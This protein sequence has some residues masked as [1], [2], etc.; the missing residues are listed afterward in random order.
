MPSSLEQYL[1]RI[2][3][4]WD[5]DAPGQLHRLIEGSM[6]FVDISGFT[7]MSERLARHGRVGAEEVTDV[8]DSTFGQLL[9]EAYAHGANL[10]KFG[11]DA[12]LLLFTE[13]GHAVRAA[14]AGQAM[15]RK[16]R[17]IGSFATSAGA[18]VLRMTMGIHSGMFD[19]FMVGRSHRELIVTGPAVTRTVE[20]ESAAETGQIL[21]SP[22]TAR[23]IP[24]RSLGSRSGPGVLLRD[25]LTEVERL[26]IRPA[27]A[28]D[29]DLAPFVPVALRER[30]LAGDLG[31][32]HRPATIAFIGYQGVDRVIGDKGA[33]TAALA[34]DELMTMVQVAADTHKVTL[35][36]TD[37]A[38]DGG[39]IILTAG[40]PIASG[41]DEE[42]LLLAVNQ[43][44]S[45]RP[46]LPIR[47]GVTWGSIFAGEVGPSYRRTYTVMGDA[48]NLAARLMAKSAPGEVLTTPEVLEGSRTLFQA[49]EVAPFF[50]KGKKAPVVAR[51]L[52][53]PTGTRIST[54]G[55]P[56]VGREAEL[57]LMLDKWS[58]AQLRPG[59][60]VELVAEPGMGKSRLLEEFLNRAAGERIVR[61]ECRL[62]QSAT[63]YF[64]FRALLRQALGID[65]NDAEKSGTQLR[66]LVETRT[67]ELVAWLP[68]IAAALNLEWLDTP[69][70]AML[71]NQFRPARTIE[72]VRYLLEGVSST[73]TI[74]VVEDTHWMDEASRELLDGLVGALEKNPW[75]LILTSRPAQAGSPAVDRPSAIQITLQPL[76]Q[77]DA[78]SLIV[79]ATEAHPLPSQQVKALA[80]R[81]AGSPLFLIELLQ[82]LKRGS[83]VDSLPQSVEGLIGARIDKLPAADRNLLRRLSVLGAGFQVEHTAAVL[84]DTKLSERNRAIHRMSG[85][86]SI[87]QSGWVQFRHALIRDVAYGGLPFNTRRRLHAQVG[88]SICAAAG[89]QVDSQAELLSFHFFQAQDYAGAWRFSLTAGRRAAHVYANVEAA[90]FLERALHAGPRRSAAGPEEL[91]DAY[92]LLGDVQERL[93]DYTRAVRAYSTARKLVPH[94]PAQAARLLDKQSLMAEHSGNF[95]QALR[96]LSQG[97][98]LLTM[99]DGPEQVG[100]RAKLMGGYGAVRLEQGQ[101]REAI[102]WARRAIAEAETTEEKAALAQAYLTLDIAL[103]EVGEPADAPYAHLALSLFEQLEDLAG[104]ANTLNNMGAEAYWRGRWDEAR[105]LFERSQRARERMGDEVNAAD[106]LNNVAE[107]L[108]DQ[109]RLAEAEA[110]FRTTLRVRQAFNHRIGLA[111][112]WS[113]LGRVA[114]RSGRNAEA[115]AFLEQARSEFAELKMAHE[116][117]ETDARIAECLL[118]GGQWE[119]AQEVIERALIEANQ[120]G[121]TTAQAPM[122]YR[123]RSWASIQAG[124]PAEAAA[125][126]AISLQHGRARGADYEVALTLNV[127]SALVRVLGENPDPLE[128]AEQHEIL[129]RL[130]VVFLPTVYVHEADLTAP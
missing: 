10:L 16:L 43:L 85:L 58:Q 120:V 66:E 6:V 42:Q 88:Q 19:F 114:Y 50:V 62:Y 27:A 51:A 38:A 68:L 90:R 49:S 24:T 28:P 71:D 44:A 112:A 60:L 84:P 65:A 34:L 46:V 73:P 80:F 128:E 57:S 37:I 106:G 111:Y 31:P 45:S 22:E 40:V 35:L 97:L 3:R 64:P 86:L 116:V 78:E 77:D 102:K 21:L 12:L 96:W 107:I 91:A 110:L 92:E 8:I 104:E 54:G 14:A 15:R 41:N 61:T 130:G 39:K 89:D 29:V 127:R 108:S 30:L 17:E 109:G 76:D 32:E 105:D 63:P 95:S 52:G 100:M 101:I 124:K 119:E 122:L 79:A 98:K 36:A 69:E 26:E 20:M 9:P 5:L 23:F 87:N 118:F 59:Q 2:V 56:L 13:T 121:G 123:L 81:A 53:A 4:Y 7:K 93:G 115:M 67:P 83:D 55:L 125:D 99:V 72:A 117:L 75:L 126:L 48:V 129:S 33:A 1:P 18:V 103:T 82:A 70:V 25:N 47:V 113:N 74:I 94:H 11:G